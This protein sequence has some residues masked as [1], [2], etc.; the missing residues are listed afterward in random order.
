[1]NDSAV[2]H[3]CRPFC[4]LSTLF[5]GFT[6]LK[7]H[8][9]AYME[10]YYDGPI[11]PSASFECIIEYFIDRRYLLIFSS[12]H[13]YTNGSEVGGGDKINDIKRWKTPLLHL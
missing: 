10:Q 4:N 11:L 5:Y 12:A 2:L 7:Q 1:M 13:I 3:E 9:Q 6:Y 8:Y